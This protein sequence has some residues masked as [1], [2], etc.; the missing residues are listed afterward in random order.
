[1]L[2]I[3]VVVNFFGNRIVTRRCTQKSFQLLII[4]HDPSF[5]RKLSVRDMVDIYYEVERNNE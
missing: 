2:I 3:I 5:L 1:M 4:T